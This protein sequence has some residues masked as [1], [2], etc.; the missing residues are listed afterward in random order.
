MVRSMGVLSEKK[1][2]TTKTLLEKNP[3]EKRWEMT[4]K[5]LTVLNVLLGRKTRVCLG[6][7]EGI[8]A[9]VMGY[10]TYLKINTKLWLEDGRR[11]LPWV[12]DTF[13]ISVEDAIGAL[14]LCMV[15]SWFNSGPEQ[16]FEIVE[17]TPERA[18][19]R[20]TRCSWWERYKEL[21][22]VIYPELVV[23]PESCK[24]HFEAGIK[25]INPKITYHHIK[26]MPRGD[27]YCEEVFEFKEE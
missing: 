26:A 11:Y 2:F 5:L 6:I 18:V 3:A 22:P 19:Y 17:D 25:A 12:K 16:K 24:A 14:K 4:A 1:K 13:N 9:P 27:P 10:E 21:F 20:T 23:C 7:G 15:A 8:I